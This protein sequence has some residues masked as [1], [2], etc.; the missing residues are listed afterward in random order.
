MDKKRNYYLLVPA[1]NIYLDK[2]ANPSGFTTHHVK[3][4]FDK[5]YI[6][7]TYQK[8]IIKVSVGDINEP[9]EA[10]ELVTNKALNFDT[11]FLDSLLNPLANP[12][13]ELVTPDISIVTACNIYHADMVKEFYQEIIDSS[14]ALDYKHAVYD[15]MGVSREEKEHKTFIKRKKKN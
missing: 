15:I 4:T 3:K 12:I 14:M 1:E 11:P 6:P 9:V 10:I 5:Y 8:I 13:I 2:E 7:N